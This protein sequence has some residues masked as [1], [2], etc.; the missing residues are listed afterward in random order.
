M[1]HC[2]ADLR[3]VCFWFSFI[4]TKVHTKSL[5]PLDTAGEPN[6]LEQW[7]PVGIEAFYRPR[8][9]SSSGTKYRLNRTLKYSFV[10]VGGSRTCPSTP[11][12][13]SS[14]FSWEQC[15]QIRWFL[16]IICPKVSFKISPN[17]WR[18]YRF[19]ENIPFQIKTPV[20]TF[21]F[22]IWSHWLGVS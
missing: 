11:R 6:R 3:L 20:A 13:A 12:S 15:D 1:Y 14:N 21:N 2:T 7:V 16:K 4:A 5:S 8:I 17:V 18:L 22:N 19:F 10:C 9:R